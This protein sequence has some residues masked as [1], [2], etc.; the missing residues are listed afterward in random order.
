M[1]DWCRHRLESTGRFTEAEALESTKPG[2][3][4]ADSAPAKQDITIVM[5]S[6]STIHSANTLLFQRFVHYQL[7][8]PR[9]SLRDTF[10]FKAPSLTTSPLNNDRRFRSPQDLRRARAAALSI[11]DDD[12]AAKATSLVI[13]EVKGK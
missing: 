3:R 7:P 9:S 4:S 8:V 5:A 11:S 12:C 2:L 13:P 1:K 10:G 6:T